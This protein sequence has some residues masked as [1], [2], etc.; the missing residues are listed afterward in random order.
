MALVK[1]LEQEQPANSSS[2]PASISDQIF[3]RFKSVRKKK[4]LLESAEVQ[5]R[6]T[7]IDKLLQ[8]IEQLSV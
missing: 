4:S 1:D 8:E 3:A 6:L 2:V 7:K 5:K